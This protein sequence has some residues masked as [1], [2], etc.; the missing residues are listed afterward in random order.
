VCEPATIT[1]AITGIVAAGTAIAGAVVEG[2]S[3]KSAATTAA[4][5]QAEEFDFQSRQERRNAELA[6]KQASDIRQLG[7]TAAGETGA[8]GRTAAA[9]ARTVAGA[10]GV[11]S[12]SG[13]SAGVLAQSEVNAAVDANRIRV[14]AAREAWGFDE[15]ARQR[16]EQAARLQRARQTAL[17]GG[18]LSRTGTDLAT[19]GRVTQ[20]A[21]NTVQGIA[22]RVG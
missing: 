4:N 13:T 16:E 6:R 10:S 2:E 1:M 7:A 3:Q 11:D 5:A 15:E 14:N 9:G 12:T 19:A 21:G 8:A 17:R 20:I 18:Y 22:G